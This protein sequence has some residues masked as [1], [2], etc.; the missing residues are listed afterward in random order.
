MVYIIRMN[1]LKYRFQRWLNG[2]IVF[3]DPV[4][5]FRPVDFSARNAPAEAASVTYALALSEV[6]LAALQAC[7]EVGVLQRNRGLRSQQLQHRDPVRCEGARSQI[8]LQ[9]E[10]ANQLHLIDD[11]HAQDG[12]G[13]LP[14]H[15]LVLRIQVPD[16]SVI[17]HHALP[18]PENVMKYGLGEI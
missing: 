16:Q 1:S 18:C 3:K 9:I 4:G 12:S 8:V 5:F 14:P 7:I 17:K 2:W 6:S 15:I 10:C 11:R 13:A